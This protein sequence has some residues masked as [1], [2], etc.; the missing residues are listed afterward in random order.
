MVMKAVLTRTGLRWL[1]QALACAALAA[2]ALA[3]S[4]ATASRASPN[5]V[6]VL[7]SKYHEA[8]PMSAQRRTVLSID[9]AREWDSVLPGSSVEDTTGR[10]VRWSREQ[11]LLY[12][13]P[14]SRQELAL[15]SPAKGLLLSSGVLYWPV[16]EKPNGPAS[17]KA[18]HSCLVSVVTRAY[19]QRIKIVD[20]KL[21]RR[22]GTSS[23]AR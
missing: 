19:W 12:A 7:A 15:S 18:S 5:H 13:P 6:R 4:T 2:P 21:M 22:D 1:L 23:A 3:A 16:D 20:P 11:V 17:R 10:K 14:P 9:S 8:C